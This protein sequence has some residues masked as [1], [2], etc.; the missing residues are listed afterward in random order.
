MSSPAYAMH[1]ELDKWIHDISLSIVSLAE[2]E[3]LSIESVRY[4]GILIRDILGDS[5]F[6]VVAPTRW[7][8]I[9]ASVV[10]GS[11]PYEENVIATSMAPQNSYNE[12]SELQSSLLGNIMEQDNEL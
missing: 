10:E 8:P 11:N 7:P 3:I 6:G 2:I 5:E 12:R 4:K 1:M 9:P